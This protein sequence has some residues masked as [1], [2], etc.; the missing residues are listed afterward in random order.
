M[1]FFS[2]RRKRESALQESSTD[3][4]EL[5]SFAKSEGQP[6]VGQQ[7]GGGQ[8]QFDVEGMGFTDGLAMLAQLGPMI[9]QAMASGNVQITQGQPE[10]LDM[11][12]TGLREE[13]MEI[14]QQH[15]IDAQAGTASQ[16]IDASAY[17]DMQQQILQALAKHGIDPNVAGS[18]VNFQISPDSDEKR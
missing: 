3:A 14:M 18:S 1:G 11:R 4:P 2:W 17:G 16:N 13:I 7:V 8:P 6:V 9:Q 12:G 15:G 10:V 5:G